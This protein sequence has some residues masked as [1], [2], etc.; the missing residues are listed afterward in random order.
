MRMRPVLA[1][2][3]ASVLSAVVA[4]CGNPS[5]SPPP[6]GPAGPL[7]KEPERTSAWT[8]NYPHGAAPAG[9]VMY[10]RFCAACH[11]GPPPPPPGGAKGPPKGNPMGGGGPRMPPGTAELMVKYGNDVPADLEQRTDLSAETVTYFVRN[12]SGVMPAIRKTELSDENLK[13][14]AEY[15]SRKR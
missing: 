6:K 3:S 11:S 1:V 10:D 9:K 14:I 2:V 13:S 12:G 4:G 8:V 5:S 15:L 7:M